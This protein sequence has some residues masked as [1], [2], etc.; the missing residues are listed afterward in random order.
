MKY[1]IV[2]NTT[3]GIR[4]QEELE[5]PSMP[6]AIEKFMKKMQIIEDDQL[7]LPVTFTIFKL[8]KVEYE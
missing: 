2:A 8:K 6:A 5:A 3:P 1:L 7:V 4:L